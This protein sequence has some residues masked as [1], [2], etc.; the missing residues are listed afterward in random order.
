MLP[1]HNFI[2][3]C[4]QSIVTLPSTYMV[5]LLKFI[6]KK[7]WYYQNKILTNQST[8]QCVVEQLQRFCL[9][10][11]EDRTWPKY[12]SMSIG[13]YLPSQ[14]QFSRKRVRYCTTRIIMLFVMEWP[15]TCFTKTATCKILG[16]NKLDVY[17]WYIYS[18]FWS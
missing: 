6:L 18:Y 7:A 16:A 3:T 10:F 11:Y 4:Y 12:S 5:M 8:T 9:L 1:K 14:T 2:L 13:N 17:I 15:E